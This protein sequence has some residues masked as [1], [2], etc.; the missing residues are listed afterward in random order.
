MKTARQIVLLVSLGRYGSDKCNL[1]GVTLETFRIQKVK[2]D[3][4]GSETSMRVTRVVS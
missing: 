2:Q 3:E 4:K 1:S